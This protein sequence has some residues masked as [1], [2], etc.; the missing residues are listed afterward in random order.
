MG[1]NKKHYYCTGIRWRPEVSKFGASGYNKCG[2]ASKKFII[3]NNKILGYCEACAPRYI[4]EE[5]E[6]MGQSEAKVAEVIYG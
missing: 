5:D 1:D 4:T 6:I 2:T 3:K